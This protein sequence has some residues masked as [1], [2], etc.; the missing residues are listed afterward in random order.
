MQEYIVVY[1]ETDVVGYDDESYLRG[2]IIDYN[3]KESKEINEMYDFEDDDE[4]DTAPIAGDE[5]KIFETE[6]VIAA[7]KSSRLDEEDKKALL[8][9]LQKDQINFKADG[10]FDE[11][12][13]GLDQYSLE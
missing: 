13:E 10:T 9:E 1:N 12:V 4:V 5:A 3:I 11:V 6:V 7:V 2:A 8:K